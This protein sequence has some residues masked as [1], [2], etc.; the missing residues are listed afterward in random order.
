MG[1]ADL[2]WTGRERKMQNENLCLQRDSNPRHTTAR[3]V[4]QRVR[5]LCH[6]ALMM[7]RGY[8]WMDNGMQINKTITWQ[9]VSNWLLYL[10]RMS[11]KIYISYLNVDFS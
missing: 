5:P 7:F 11:D 2:F 6:V 8:V 3:Q 4:N 1:S 9:H 10:N